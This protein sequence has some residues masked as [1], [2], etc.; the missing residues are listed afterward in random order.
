MIFE[1]SSKAFIIESGRIIREVTIQKSIGDFYIIHFD[2]GRGGIQVR[3]SRLYC[4]KGEAEAIISKTE[5]N[6]HHNAPYDY[7]H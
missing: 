4:N 5:K 2:D 1:I 6:I 7:W 3:S